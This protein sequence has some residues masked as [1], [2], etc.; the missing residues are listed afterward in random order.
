MID[1]DRMNSLRDDVGADEFDEVVEIFLEEVDEIIARLADKPDATTLEA[2]LHALKGCALGLGFR[3][4]AKLC[5]AAEGLCGEGK[6]TEVN[7]DAI[8]RVYADSRRVFLDEL[9]AALAG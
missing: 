4:F 9:P 2:D 8:L 3:A 5:Q 6:E 1:W 7:L